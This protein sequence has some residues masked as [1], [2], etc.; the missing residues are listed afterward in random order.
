MDRFIES[1]SFDR[2]RSFALGDQIISTLA[3]LKT[4]Q[5][6]ILSHN[7]LAYL[8]KFPRMVLFELK[9][10]IFHRLPVVFVV[11]IRYQS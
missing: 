1:E 4:S 8:S 2:H 3:D 6:G 9:S 7:L 10:V 11:R 5:F